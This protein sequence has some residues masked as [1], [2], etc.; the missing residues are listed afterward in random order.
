VTRALRLIAALAAS[1]AFTWLLCE[2]ALR[3]APGLIPP[4]LLLHFEPAMRETLAEGRFTTHK[5]VR[6]LERDD[7]GPELFL[8]RPFA[9]K[10]YPLP[11]EYVVHTVR[12]DALG[13]CNEPGAAE[14]A[15]HFDLL[16]VGDSFT[17]CHAVHPGETWVARLGELTGLATYNLGRGGIGPHEEVQILKAFGTRWSP[18]VVVMNLYEG[19]DLRDA[20][21]V[22]EFRRGVS[23][24][25]G[26]PVDHGWHAWAPARW[27]RAFDLAAAALTQDV[28]RSD[29]S[30]AKKGVDFHY[31]VD[32]GGESFAFNPHNND[33][34]EVVFARR[35]R[36]GEVA[37]DVY[38][39]ALASFAELARTHGFRP[40]LAYS[41]S[42]HT[43]YRPWV[44]YA[45]PG[46]HELLEWFS[47]AQRAWLAERCRAL[48]IDFVDLTPA[49]RAA[50]REGE[51]GDLLYIPSSV[52]YTRRGHEVAARALAAALPPLPAAAPGADQPA[53]RVR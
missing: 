31:R 38:A 48:G 8:F 43:A 34:D 44:T 17:F 45:E 5:H 52:H 53:A 3:A 7:G 46:L 32:I 1:A 6:R 36:A 20:F 37:F 33:R 23:E 35:V 39:D 26:V 29:Y 21:R 19:N 9:E 47:G 11:E 40:V 10:H 4:D 18:R 25:D 24:D 50:A 22:Q 28:Y 51:P 16:A 13:F 41:P 14:G 42:A 2:L 30:R 49:L 12:T 27:S 15:T